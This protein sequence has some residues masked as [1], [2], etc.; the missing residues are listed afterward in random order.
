[1]GAGGVKLAAVSPVGVNHTTLEVVEVFGSA[2]TL[3]VSGT[4]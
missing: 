1:M 4:P 2:T 3:P